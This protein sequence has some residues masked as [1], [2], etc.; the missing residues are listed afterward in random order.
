[1]TKKSSSE[2]GRTIALKT[3]NHARYSVAA[4]SVVSRTRI[5]DDYTDCWSLLAFLS[6]QQETI[7]AVII[8]TFQRHDCIY[9]RVSLCP[10]FEKVT[11]IVH[12]T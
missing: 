6:L 3:I 7:N 12:L 5:R 1:M 4:I 2:P 9:V 8:K 11:L 10:L